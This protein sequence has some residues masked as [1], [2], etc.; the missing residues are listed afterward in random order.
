[1]RKLFLF[2]ILLMISLSIQS[3]SSF[4]KSLD[5]TDVKE[6]FLILDN[7]FQIEITNT[8]ENKIIIQAVSEGEYQ[9]H[10]LIHSKRSKNTLTIKDTIQPFSENYNDKLST[11]KL[12]SLYVKI[13][14]PR[15]LKVTLQSKLAS[16]IV[17]AETKSLFV[18]LNSGDCLLKKFIGN[19]LVNTTVGNIAIYTKN[20]NVKTSTKS[21]QIIREKIYGQHQIQLKSISGNISVYKTK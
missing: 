6:I 13:Q 17:E 2:L 10:V 18:E 12:I 21:G 4:N 1:M 8:S 11:H 20:A 19:A 15:H 16:L 3:Q 7:A 5:V 14:I 9:N